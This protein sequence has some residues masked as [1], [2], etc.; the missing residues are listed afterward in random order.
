MFTIA[1][2]LYEPEISG[3]RDKQESKALKQRLD[4]DPPQMVRKLM[5]AGV[6]ARKKWAIT[7]A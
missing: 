2:Q 1:L 4:I 3:A 5:A 6:K 7:A